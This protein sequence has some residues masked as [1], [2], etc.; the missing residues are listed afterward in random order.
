MTVLAHGGILPQYQPA[1]EGERQIS[2]RRKGVKQGAM[3][4]LL[5]ALVVPLLGL[6]AGYAPGRI[7]D[8]FGFFT[9]SA[10]II[11]FLGGALRM[12]YAAL[13]EEGAPARPFLPVPQVP[14]ATQQGA[15]LPNPPRMAA[16]P[17]ASASP[18]LG[19][20][21]RPQTAEIVQP[22]SV[23]DNTTQLLGKS[24]PEDGHVN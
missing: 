17:P 20:R 24:K 16:L 5:G 4:F 8:V 1:A 23:T 6:F 2:A 12:L 13:F 19:W 9:A 21:S 22:P 10:A 3:L 7:A 11:C 14:Y 15:A 18:P